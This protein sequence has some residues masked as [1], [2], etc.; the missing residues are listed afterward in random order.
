MWVVVAIHF[1]EGGGAQSHIWQK[2]QMWGTQFRYGPPAQRWRRSWSGPKRCSKPRAQVCRPYKGSQVRKFRTGIVGLFTVLLFLSSAGARPFP[3]LL[4]DAQNFRLTIRED[5]ASLLPLSPS[6]G[7]E[8]RLTLACRA[9]VVTLQNIGTRTVH[10]SKFICQEPRVSFEMKEPNSSFG[11]WPISRG[12]APRCAPWTYEN[13]RLKPGEKT[14]YKTRLV[15]Q[16]RPAEL[17][18]P[19][20]PH[21]YII[22]ARWPLWGCIEETEGIDCLAPLQVMKPTSYGTSVGDVEIQTP[23]EVVSN[24]IEVS[25]PPLPDF[26]PLKLGIEISVAPESQASEQTKLFPVCA[27]YPGSIECMVFH[28]SI[29]NLGDRPVRSVDTCGR[30]YMFPEYRA[31]DGEWKQ[32]MPSQ[33]AM[34]GG[35]CFFTDTPILPG[36][37]EER[38][39]LISWEF[40]T[41]PLYPAGKY[42][43]RFRFRPDACFASPDGSFCLQSPKEQIETT[44]NVITIHTTAFTGKPISTQ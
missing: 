32:L 11:W 7:G 29:R 8:A 16:S 15:S 37:T 10:L 41:S 13:I 40:D 21:S 19:V 9:F 42:E 31:N 30:G 14:E 2:R 26:G 1:S 3:Q 12:S 38:N 35:S 20:A 6:C 22:R 5:S 44:S 25:S 18:T 43:I 17:G 34:R 33:I 39:Q 28:Y 36:K 4:P 24:E 23:V 27:T